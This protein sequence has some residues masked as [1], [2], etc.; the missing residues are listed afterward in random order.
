M[1]QVF[2]ISEVFIISW[3]YNKM[4]YDFILRILLLCMLLYLPMTQHKAL[5]HVTL[6]LQ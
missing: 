3:Y 4:I 6:S 5:F 2:K 1:L